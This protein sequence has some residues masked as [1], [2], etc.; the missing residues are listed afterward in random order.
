MCCISRCLLAIKRKVAPLLPIRLLLLLSTEASTKRFL[1]GLSWLSWYQS[2]KNS[3]RPS[4]LY[5]LLFGT[6]ELDLVCKVSVHY[7]RRAFQF[8]Y[9]LTPQSICRILLCI[10]RTACTEGECFLTDLFTAFFVVGCPPFKQ[11]CCRKC[12]KRV[13]SHRFTYSLT[14]CYRAC[15]RNR[16]YNQTRNCLFW[17]QPCR[18]GKY[19]RYISQL[20]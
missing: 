8:W 10:E 14:H 7:S 20:I 5:A 16:L 6:S 1:C 11:N 17:T 2:K 13:P 12:S 18:A 9:K 15:M 19:W 4:I 3:L